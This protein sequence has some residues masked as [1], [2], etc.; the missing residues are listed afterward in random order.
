MSRNA[1]LGRM[2]RMDDGLGLRSFS[3][4]TRAATMS[5]RDVMAS[6]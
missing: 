5:N 3:G 1:E 4:Y 6:Y 2:L